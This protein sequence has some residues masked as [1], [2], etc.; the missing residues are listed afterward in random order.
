MTRFAA[1]VIGGQPEFVAM[2]YP[3]LWELWEAHDEPEWL[4]AHVGRLRARYGVAV[5]LE[6]R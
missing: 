4:T 1:S 6:S 2:S 5:T 3:E